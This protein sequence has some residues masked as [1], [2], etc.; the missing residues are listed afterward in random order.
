MLPGLILVMLST[1]LCGTVSP[2]RR[3][4][5][6]EFCTLN[7]QRSWSKSLGSFKTPSLVDDSQS[8]G[9]ASAI[10]HSP[11]KTATE[12]FRSAS[13]LSLHPLRV[14]GSGGGGVRERA[15]KKTKKKKSGGTHRGGGGGEKRGGRGVGGREPRE[16]EGGG[17]GPKGRKRRQKQDQQEGIEGGPS[18][19]NGTHRSLSKD[20]RE[21]AEQT[22]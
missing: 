2:V 21:A 10:N 22:V 9:T 18:E 4:H 1:G 17:G 6:T 16:Q 5:G 8:V 20:Y 14:R 12:R 13:L 3:F 11:G 15:G 7:A 19:K